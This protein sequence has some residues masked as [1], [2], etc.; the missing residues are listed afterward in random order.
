MKETPVTDQNHPDDAAPYEAGGDA[1]H[2]QI[3]GKITLAKL[4]QLSV[5][6]LVLSPLINLL[7][8]RNKEGNRF[9]IKVNQHV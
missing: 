3:F 6:D 2:D 7:R 5:Q 1:H 4:I 9:A 8:L